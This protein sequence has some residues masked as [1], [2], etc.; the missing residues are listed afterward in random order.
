MGPC[1][2]LLCCTSLSGKPPPYTPPPSVPTAP[3]SS[4]LWQAWSPALK[5]PRPAVAKQYHASLSECPTFSDSTAGGPS[6]SSIVWRQLALGAR[7]AWPAWLA[8]LAT[9]WITSWSSRTYRGS[10]KIDN[11]ANSTKPKPRWLREVVGRWNAASPGFVSRLSTRCWRC[12]GSSDWST[13]L[14]VTV[15]VVRTDSSTVTVTDYRH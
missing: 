7:V 12:R 11:G 5:N 2:S 10:D 14:R 6:R 15:P 3:R 8:S 9:A 13:I 1:I 4:C